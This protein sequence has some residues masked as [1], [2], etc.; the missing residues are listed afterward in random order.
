MTLYM[1]RTVFPSIVR[2]SILY[3]QQ[4]N[5]YCCLLASKQAAVSVWHMPIAVC[6]VLNSWWWTERPSGTC[7]V[8]FQNKIIL[9]TGACS[10]FYYRNSVEKS[11]HDAEVQLQS[12]ATSVVEGGRWSVQRRGCSPPPPG[13]PPEFEWASGP[14]WTSTENLAPTGSRS[15]CRPTRSSRYAVYVIPVAINQLCSLGIK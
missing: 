12:S 11:L 15:P 7:R 6:T 14:V 13:N 2:S 3:I 8:S 9:Y 5:R 4:P 10:W 1:F